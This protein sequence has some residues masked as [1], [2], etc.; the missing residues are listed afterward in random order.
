MRTAGD[1][2]C[3]RQCECELGSAARAAAAHTPAAACAAPPSSQVASPALPPTAA[4]PL[5]PPPAAPRAAQ[6]PAPPHAASAP[7]PPPRC[8]APPA[9]HR[10]RLAAPRHAALRRPAAAAPALPPALAARR[11]TAARHSAPWP[12]P[13]VHGRQPAPWRRPVGSPATT[14]ACQWAGKVCVCA[15][16]VQGHAPAARRLVHA[17]PFGCCASRESCWLPSAACPSEAAGALAGAPL[18]AKGCGGAKSG[19]GVTHGHRERTGWRRPAAPT[20]PEHATCVA[21]WHRRGAARRRAASSVQ[22]VGAS[23]V[24]ATRPGSPALP[25]RCAVPPSARPPG[26]VVPA[27]AAC[28]GRRR[29]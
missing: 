3:A 11:A 21:S 23:R 13:A 2:R 12:R 28:A 29:V 27:H 10:G 8:A 24:H 9:P 20:A 1:T 19:R 14:R 16:Y 15:A 5:P 26:A 22:P 7:C 18:R 4:A 25:P 17:S 6:T